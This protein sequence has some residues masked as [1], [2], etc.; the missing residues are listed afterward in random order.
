MNGEYRTRQRIRED[1][2]TLI[3]PEC[4]S[5]LGRKSMLTRCYNQALSSLND[6]R[7][8]MHFYLGRPVVPQIAEVQREL[9]VLENLNKE[10]FDREFTTNWKRK[11]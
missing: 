11:N 4:K 6:M 7:K 3:L 10:L 2:I 9:E 8:C 1:Y 5:A